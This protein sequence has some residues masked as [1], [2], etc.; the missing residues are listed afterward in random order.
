MADALAPMFWRP[1]LLHGTVELLVSNAY[2]G[3]K[4]GD[5]ML[6]DC[7]DRNRPRPSY[8]RGS[9]LGKTMKAS[10]GVASAV[11]ISYGRD[12]DPLIKGPRIQF[13]VNHGRDSLV[14][15]DIHNYRTILALIDSALLSTTQTFF[16]LEWIL[17][18][19]RVVTIPIDTLVRNMLRHCWFALMLRGLPFKIHRVMT[20]LRH[21][22]IQKV[23]CMMKAFA[24]ALHH[25]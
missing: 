19:W 21:A 9:E 4:N 1:V 20:E 7:A 18:M 5:Q 13:P 6:A 23:L 15:V 10:H 8:T 25:K 12:A 17:Q 2:A 22:L 11:N 3:K 14:W 16:K 24:F